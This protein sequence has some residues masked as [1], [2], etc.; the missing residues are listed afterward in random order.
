VYVVIK[1]TIC[2]MSFRDCL[3]VGQGMLNFFPLQIEES[4]IGFS[5]HSFVEFVHRGHISRGDLVQAKMCVRKCNV[6]SETSGAAFEQT[7]LD[8]WDKNDVNRNCTYGGI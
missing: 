1:S 5:E 3:T 8:N 7:W 6:S 2:S 4:S